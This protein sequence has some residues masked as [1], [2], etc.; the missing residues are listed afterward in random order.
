MECP[1]NMQFSEALFPQIFPPVEEGEDPT[2]MTGDFATDTQPRPGRNAFGQKPRWPREAPGGIDRATDGPAAHVLF[3]PSRLH[4]ATCKGFIEEVT[5]LLDSAPDEQR[6]TVD[7]LDPGGRSPLH[8]AAGYGHLDIVKLLLA[9]KCKLEVR[10]MW[11]KAPVDWAI[12]TQQHEIIELLRIEAVKQKIIGGKG[13][14]AP[15]KTK[16]EFATGKTFEEIDE[17][18]CNWE[19]KVWD[20]HERACMEERENRAP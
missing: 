13:E 9:R 16:C 6:C 20:K 14:V 12:Q 19:N 18:M 2:V 17:F 5:W 15:L 3:E 7:D 11:M 4:E 8:F 1:P 10:D